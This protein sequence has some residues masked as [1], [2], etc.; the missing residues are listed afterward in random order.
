M[1]PPLFGTAQNNYSPTIANRN[2]SN[3]TKKYISYIFLQVELLYVNI[4][5]FLTAI[6]AERFK[7]DISEILE[8]IIGS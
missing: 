3:L 8:A 1:K 7:M 6:L 2:P 5:G 4:N